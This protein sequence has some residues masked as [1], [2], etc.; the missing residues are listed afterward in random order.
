MSL[1]P[2]GCSEVRDRL[3]E[4]AL[5]VV[6][7]EEAERVQRHLDGCTGCRKELA[8][9]DEGAATMAFALPQADPPRALEHRVVERVAQASGR[10]VPVQMHRRLRTQVRRLA[11]VTLVT[12]IL[13]GIS[14]GWAFTERL[15]S[16]EVRQAS[17][18]K[19]QQLGR[20]LAN[21]VKSLGEAPLEAAL[22]PTAGRQGTGTA[23][24]VSIPKHDDLILVVVYLVHGS[25]G[26]YEVRLETRSQKVYAVGELQRTKDG[27]LLYYD[28]SGLDL[29]KVQFVSVLDRQ[30][31]PVMTGVVRPFSA[32]PSP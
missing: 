16:A 25:D 12:A 10:R 13:A 20:H 15:T 6:P 1:A 19:V 5:G 3:A 28:N 32:T 23:T 8:E 27:T 4:L 30:A 26:P 11:S 29:S 2:L 31:R 7:P 18:D 17:E 24:I 22:A 9:L 21:V 14:V